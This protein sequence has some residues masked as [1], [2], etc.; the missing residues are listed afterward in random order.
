MEMLNL[1]GPLVG[2]LMQGALLASGARADVAG[3]TQVVA[4]PE[5]GVRLGADLPAGVDTA[6]AQAAIASLTPAIELADLAFPPN[7]DNIDAVLA[8]D[9]YQRHVILAADSRQGGD[10]AGLSAH[11]FRRGALAAEV[12]DPQA[13]TG[14]IPDLLVHVAS[15]LAAF[16]ERLEAGDLVICGSAVP[17]PL[18]EPDET[19]FRYELRPIGAAAVRF[20]G[21]ED[22]P[23]M[24]SSRLSA[25]RRQ[26]CT[27]LSMAVSACRARARRRAKVCAVL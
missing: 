4:E 21:D 15:M 14:R 12:P 26:F 6:T 13:L 27:S 8:A 24:V 3:W 16:G 18:I 1:A 10:T 17:P 7:H 20:R 23:G 2:Y 11:V 19:E 5:I 9:I 22:E 25:A